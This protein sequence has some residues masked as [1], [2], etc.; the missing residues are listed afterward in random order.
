MKLLGILLPLFLVPFLT[1][2]EYRIKTVEIMPVESY[3][4]HVSSG[5]ITIAADP[6][7]DDDKCNTA[8]DVKKL[9]SR[10]YFPVYIIIRNGSPYYLK[11]KTRNITLE[12]RLG[13]QLYSTPAA[14]VVEEVFGD[15]YGDSLS[16]TITGNST[17][18]K[19]ASPLSDF[20]G[21]ELTNRLIDPGTVYSGFLFFFSEKTKKSIFIGSTLHI[22]GLEEEGT[23]KAFG[24]F[25]IPLDPA[26]D[27]PE[28]KD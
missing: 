19:I 27:I 9:A 10:G 13:L 7:P 5:E 1:A 8:F 20:T 15:K 16:T 21:K 18:G 14:M 4:A 17:A 25:E 6:Y 3:P 11:I 24:P 28:L 23:M 22:P 12:T 2:S 26:L